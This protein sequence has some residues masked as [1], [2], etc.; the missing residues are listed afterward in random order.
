MLRRGVLSADRRVCAVAGRRDQ[1]QKI[2]RSQ[3]D[4]AA[5]RDRSAVIGGMGSG[6]RGMY[7]D[8]WVVVSIHLLEFSAIQ[9]LRRD[10][11]IFERREP[12]EHGYAGSQP[13]LYNYARDAGAVGAVGGDAGAVRETHSEIVGGRG[14]P[15][16]FCLGRIGFN[17]TLGGQIFAS[18]TCDWRGSPPPKE[19]RKEPGC[20]QSYLARL[21]NL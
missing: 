5:G 20:D 2:L 17:A 3:A 8:V 14:N 12:S 7:F 21:D 6:D 15:R 11:L 19:G 10:D 4:A 18:S 1:R 16:S 13:D 9:F